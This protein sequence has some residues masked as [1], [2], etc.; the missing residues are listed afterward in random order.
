MYIWCFSGNWTIISCGYIAQLKFY[1][2]CGKKLKLSNRSWKLPKFHMKQYFVLYCIYKKI[3]S[4]TRNRHSNCLQIIPDPTQLFE[5]S[6]EMLRFVSSVRVNFAESF[7]TFYHSLHRWYHDISTNF[8]IFKLRLLF[9]DF[10][11][12]SA[13]RLW[14]CFVNTMFEIYGLVLD[15]ASD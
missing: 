5:S 13:T 4:E 1:N 2:N 15:T 11:D 12:V 10:S 9:I 3:W 14:S 8:M 6:R 7:S